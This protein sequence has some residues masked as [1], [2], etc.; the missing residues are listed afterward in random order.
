MLMS[1][2]RARG[3][4]GE[5]LFTMQDII[6]ELVVNQSTVLLPIFLKD[7]EEG[8]EGGREKEGRKIRGNLIQLGGGQG[9]GVFFL[10]LHR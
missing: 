10:M 2:G 6:H 3:E 9:F 5:V 1:V 7:R 4:G 8:R